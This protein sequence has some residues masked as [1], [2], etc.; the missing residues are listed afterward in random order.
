VVGSTAS[1]SSNSTLR[2]KLQWAQKYQL[3]RARPLAER[4]AQLFV[5]EIY[6]EADLDHE[7]MALLAVIAVRA[8][9][10]KEPL[11]IEAGPGRASSPKP[12]TCATR[13]PAPSPFW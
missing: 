10:R 8:D 12:A 3:W 13:T 5:D 11:A 2:L 7:K 1:L 9:G 4:W 6:F